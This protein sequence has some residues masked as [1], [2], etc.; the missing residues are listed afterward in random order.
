MSRPSPKGKG[1]LAEIRFLLAGALHD[2]I[3][4]KPWGDN[5]PFDHL[6]GRGKRFHRVQV[7][8]TSTVHCRGY[9]I[10]CFRPGDRKPY[11]AAEIDVLAAYVV[12]EDVWYLIP[13][14][15]LAGRKT[16]CL[17]PRRPRSYGRFERY[18]EDWK[19]LER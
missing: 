4:A 15:A 14:R 12:P 3:I 7:K 13:V 1:E 9:H 19:V 18:R 5:L 11:T 6:A 17:H 10:S 16:I 2:L 8:S